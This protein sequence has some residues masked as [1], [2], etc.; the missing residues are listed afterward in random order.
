MNVKPITPVVHKKVLKSEPDATGI[1]KYV[2]ATDY[3]AGDTIPFMITGT[4]PSL[5][6]SYETYTY[7]FTDTLPKGLTLD[8]DSIKVQDEKVT[9]D[10]YAKG[11]NAPK[12]ETKLLTKDT[13]GTENDWKATVTI[14]KDGTTSLKVDVHNLKNLVANHTLSTDDTIVVTYNAKLKPYDA[15]SD[16]NPV[17]GKTGNSNVKDVDGNVNKV[18]LTYSNNPSGDGTGTTTDKNAKVYT[19]EL[20]V[21]KVTGQKAL[22]GAGFTLYKKDAKGEYKKVKELNPDDAVAGSDPNV[23]NKYVFKELDQ[24]EYKIS[25]TTV[26]K[27][28][29]KADDV[30]F[31]ITATFEGQNSA[32]AHLETLSVGNG[33]TVD[34]KS[35]IVST[36][37]NNVPYKDF[38]LPSTGGMGRY[39]FLAV[40]ALVIVAAVAFPSLKKKKLQ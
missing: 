33:F 28:Y 3:A 10:D 26:P 18:N 7:Y 12:N 19:Y 8:E 36:N 11:I 4:I 38:V 27:G 25:E 9:S 1:R 21:N 14:K 34:K 23:K 30:T 2:D 13:D 39:I 40:G 35:G 22:A 17:I 16:D 24:G 6:K 32:D 31:T 5:I 15:K 29:H 20:D 37:V